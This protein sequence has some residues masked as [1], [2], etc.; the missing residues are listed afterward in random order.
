MLRLSLVYFLIRGANGLLSV[1]ALALLSRF[2]TSEDYG[3]YALIVAASA[4][5]A[6]VGFQWINVAVARF[7]AVSAGQRGPLIYEALRFYGVMLFPLTIV[8]VVLVGLPPW[9]WM[10]PNVGILVGLG[11]LGLAIHALGLQFANAVGVPK[12]YS[13][14]TL[15]RSLVGL[16]LAVS[17]V[18]L[19]FSAEGAAAGFAVAAFLSVLAIRQVWPEF[20]LS[21]DSKLRRS[22]LSYG[23]PLGI[24]YISNMTLEFSGRFLVGFFYGESAVG[25]F[26]AGFDLVQLI[27]GSS[28]NALFLAA[29]PLVV[30]DWEQGGAAVA[31]VSMNRL[32][33][34]T[35]LSLPLIIASFVV[36]PGQVASVVFGESL[37]RGAIEVMPWAVAAIV[38]STLKAF[39][40]DVAFQLAKRT[41][42]QLWI[43]VLMALV[44]LIM[45]MIL[46]PGLGPQGA[47]IAS[48][49][50]FAVGALL[51]WWFG[52]TQFLYDLRMSVLLKTAFVTAV[53]SITAL[54]TNSDESATFQT[55]MLTLI[56]MIVAFAAS[57]W[58]V[59]L[60]GFRLI[61]SSIFRRLGR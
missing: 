30:R 59:D 46:L 44:N 40:L 33:D 36:L 13:E 14:I 26:A 11:A 15:I 8:M 23:L 9:P 54:Q 37:R 19:G 61:C 18:L 17:L 48:T 43:T 5:I 41:K 16:G 20:Q 56:W 4:V 47:A 50:A 1:L 35:L 27:A 60:G 32:L 7:Y 49:I 12:V 29:Y 51:S 58:A 3:R 2:L 28:A 25:G 31:K 10:S 57:S 6:T 45:A 21:S 42:L 24:V 55:L 52:R 22:M 39:Y 38:F 53:V 34:L